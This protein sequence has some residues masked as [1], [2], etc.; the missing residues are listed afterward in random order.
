MTIESNSIDQPGDRTDAVSAPTGF[1]HDHEI[2]LIDVLTQLAIRKH[3]I[4]K[5][6]GAAALMGLALSFLLPVRY[7]AT[8]RI[9]PPQQTQSA[10]SILMSQL[11]GMSGSPLAA[12]T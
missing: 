12:M 3:L 8:T 4:A 9:M 6:T 5:V 11:A 1:S 7:T 10:A 2:N